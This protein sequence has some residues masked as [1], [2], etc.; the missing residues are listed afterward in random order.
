MAGVSERLRPHVMCTITL[1]TCKRPY[2]YTHPRV[3]ISSLGVVF[4]KEHIEYFFKACRPLKDIHTNQQ[5]YPAAWVDC[6]LSVFSG[7]SLC[8]LQFAIS[9][10][11]SAFVFQRCFSLFSL[12]SPVC[13]PG[14]CSKGRHTKNCFLRMDFS[15]ELFQ[16]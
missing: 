2:L 12:S 11:H 4:F 1:Q 3:Q 9:G 5:G 10:L 6:L 15:P 7:V 16:M 13:F 14:N 8:F